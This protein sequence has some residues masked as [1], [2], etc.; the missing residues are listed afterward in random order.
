MTPVGTSLTAA[1]LLAL[2][3]IAA[4]VL[5]RRTAQHAGRNALRTYSR[6][7]PNRRLATGRRRE[8]TAHHQ[9]R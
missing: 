2:I 9:D 4:Y 7:L 1:V 8:R 6:A 3:T 5:H